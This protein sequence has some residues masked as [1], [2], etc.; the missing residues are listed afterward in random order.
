MRMLAG[1]DIG[2][3]VVAV[4]LLFF[5]VHECLDYIFWVDLKARILDRFPG[6]GLLVADTPR[7]PECHLRRA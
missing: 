7:G 1:Q 3:T 2:A 6:L 4:L 5:V